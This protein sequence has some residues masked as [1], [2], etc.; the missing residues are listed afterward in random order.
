MTSDFKGSTIS[1]NNRTRLFLLPS[2]ARRVR[3]FEGAV[4]APAGAD[5][6]QVLRPL[7]TCLLAM[8]FAMDPV[9]ACGQGMLR[10]RDSTRHLVQNCSPIETIQQVTHQHNTRILSQ[11]AETARGTKIAVRHVSETVDRLVRGAAMVH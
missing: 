1:S 11:A 5:H 6:P 3:I 4:V 9:T 7:T 10:P 2:G 8:D